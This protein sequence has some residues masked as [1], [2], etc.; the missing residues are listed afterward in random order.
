[1]K[2]PVIY[3]LK[4]RAAIDSN[5]RAGAQEARLTMQNM[6]QEELEWVWAFNVYDLV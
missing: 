4:N 5:E 1:M 6:V 2:K 3:H